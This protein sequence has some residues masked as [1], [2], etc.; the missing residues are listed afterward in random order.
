MAM[1]TSKDQVELPTEYHRWKLGP[2]AWVE[3]KIAGTLTRPAL[4][5]L[6]AFMDLIDPVLGAEEVTPPCAPPL[7]PKMPTPGNGE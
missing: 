5:K 4:A 6:R 1:I 2:N 7:P 3:M